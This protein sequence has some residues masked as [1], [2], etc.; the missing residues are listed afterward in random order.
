LVQS[1]QNAFPLAHALDTE[2]HPPVIGA[3]GVDRSRRIAWM[4]FM[5]ARMFGHEPPADVLGCDRQSRDGAGRID[6]RAAVC[7]T[8]PH[9]GERFG[10][11]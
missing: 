4:P 6:V 1:R 3:D 7:R 8:R 9:R 10:T 11:L 2:R 5:D